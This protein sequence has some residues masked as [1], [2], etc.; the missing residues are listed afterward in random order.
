MKITCDGIVIW[1]VKTGESDRIITVLTDSGLI[2]AYARS[3]MKPGSK[4]TGSTAMLA[5]SNFELSTGKNMYTVVDATSQNR[6]P[7]IYSDTGKYAL[8]TYFCELLRDLAPVEED[9]T[10]FVRLFQNCL[11]LLDKDNKPIWQ[12]KAVFELSIMTLAGYMPDVIECSLCGE[13]RSNGGVFFDSQNATW[14]C[15]DCLIKINRPANYS[16]SVIS[17]VRYIVLSDPKKAFAFSLSE[18][19]QKELNRLCETFVLDHLEKK[20]NTLDFYHMM[21]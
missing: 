6:F 10:E 19:N 13:S 7:G 15:S 11:Y 17:A 5:F 12:I 1:E 21:S 20:P 3:S 16:Y 4:L 18:N 14:I 9:S 2:T 8:A